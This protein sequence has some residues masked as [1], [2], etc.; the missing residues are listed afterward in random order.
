[1]A[2]K[3]MFNIS[4]RVQYGFLALL[5]L[6][7][8]PSGGPVHLGVIARDLHL[9][10][11]YLENIFKLLSKGGIV[12]GRRGPEGGYVLKKNPRELRLFDIFKAIEGPVF[13]VECFD[14]SSS[15]SH[16]SLCPVR[17]LWGELRL[18]LETFLKRRT[19]ADIKKK[20]RKSAV[21]AHMEMNEVPARAAARK[22]NASA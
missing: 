16:L 6:A 2:E 4:T 5:A 17:D 1:V 15:C 20:Y 14:A 10:F 7:E 18:N 21:L 9:S 3:G 13:T 22:G 19:L 12:T 8:N 11:K